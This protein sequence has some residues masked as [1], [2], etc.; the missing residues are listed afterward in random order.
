MTIKP[1]SILILGGTS[2]VGR[3]LTEAALAQ[4][5]HITLFNRGQSNPE[6]FA[7]VE[8]LTG[9]R[10]TDLSALAQAVEQA[11][12]W[13]A[14]IDVTGYIPRTVR[15]SA[16]LLAKATDH[17][18]YISTISVYADHK[19]A[20]FDETYPLGTLSAEVLAQVQSKSDITGENYGPLKALCEH[21]VQQVFGT[22]A[23]I[24][25][26]DLL[27]GRTVWPKE[28]QYWH[29]ADPKTTPNSLM[30]ATL[31]RG[32]CIGWFPVPPASTTQLAQIMR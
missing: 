1:H 12:R 32:R 23:L 18:T 14:V 13:D 17:F 3:H 22:Q 27:I 6:L 9:D 11:R 16:A 7:G 4:G 2:F 5:H 15:A 21:E 10:E 20:N 28:A 31:P 19:T 24:I 25:R 29:L 30:P 26:P 8:R